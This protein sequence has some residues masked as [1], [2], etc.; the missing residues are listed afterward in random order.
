MPKLYTSEKE[1]DGL[2]EAA[3]H[4]L[5]VP[6]RCCPMASFRVLSANERSQVDAF[7][8]YFEDCDKNGGFRS[9]FFVLTK[10]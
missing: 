5:M 1:V 8:T 4:G 6:A 3:L 7:K 2:E 9:F 10:K